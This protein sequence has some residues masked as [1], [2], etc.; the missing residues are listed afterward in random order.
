MN[1]MTQ[2]VLATIAFLATHYL[3]STPLRARLVKSLGDEV[4]LAVYSAAA[5]ATLGWM[6][7][8]FRQA[9]FNN[10]WYAIDLRHVPLTLMPFALIFV[11]CGLLTA[12]P[13][14]VGQSRVLKTAQPARGILR[15]TRHPAMWGIA[16]WAGS[17]IAARGDVAGIIFFGGFLALAL[18]G[19]VLIDR[20]KA[21]A[22]GDDWRRFHAVTSNLPFAAILRGKNQF[23]L[24]EIGWWKIAIGLALYVIL[25]WL[26]PFLFGAH[27]R[28]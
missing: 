2:L 3:S 14:A 18:S 8:A 11:V 16:L 21:K 24:A 10:L 12:N 22:L 23:K 19:T 7:W 25:R 13:T 27:T 1:P 9:P 20:R 6:I 17:H 4:Y 5:F 15:V 28:F 26:H